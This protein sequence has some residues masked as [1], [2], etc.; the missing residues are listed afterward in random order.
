[1][2]KL[3]MILLNTI[4]YYVKLHQLNTTVVN[5]AGAFTTNIIKK[6]IAH[7]RDIGIANMN[8]MLIKKIRNI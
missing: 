8:V 7:G 6:E 4:E 1:M 5:F 3:K 2:P